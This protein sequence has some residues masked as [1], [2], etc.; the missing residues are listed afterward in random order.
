MD[1]Y[2]QSINQYNRESI[3]ETENEQR[4]TRADI[5]VTRDTVMYYIEMNIGPIYKTTTIIL[6]CHPI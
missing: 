4:M 3:I 2:P 5:Y 1:L 6:I